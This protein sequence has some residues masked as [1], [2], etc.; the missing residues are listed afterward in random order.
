MN[1]H[2]CVNPYAQILRSGRHGRQ[3]NLPSVIVHY[4]AVVWYINDALVEFFAIDQ[5]S[6]CHHH[7]NVQNLWMQW[8]LKTFSL[9][10]AQFL[11]RSWVVHGLFSSSKLHRFNT[12][13]SFLVYGDVQI[14]CT[15]IQMFCLGSRDVHCFIS[16]MRTLPSTIPKEKLEQSEADQHC[17]GCAIHGAKHDATRLIFWWETDEIVD[18]VEHKCKNVHHKNKIR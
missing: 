1:T 10:T 18:A 2:K 8:H 11:R 4:E 17:K 7:C 6:L 13:F 5:T 12:A 3:C 16:L 9:Y 14:L 15:D